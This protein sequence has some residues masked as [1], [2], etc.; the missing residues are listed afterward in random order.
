[1]NLSKKAFITKLN[2]EDVDLASNIFDK[3]MLCSKTSSIV[4]VTYFCT[5]NVWKNLKAISGEFDVEVSL[6]GMFKESDRRM[7]AFSPYKEVLSFPIDLLKVTS[8]TKFNNIGHRDY[9]GAL[10]ALGIKREKIGDLVL[11]NGVCYFPVCS[12]LSDYIITNLNSVGKCPCCAVIAE[13]DSEIEIENNFSLCSINVAS[14]RIDSI[15]AKL[16]NISRATAQ[17][18]IK[19]GKVQVDYEI[20]KIDKIVSDDV[21]ITIR[22][23][24]KYKVVENVGFTK[25]GK[26]KVSVKKYI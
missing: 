14:M 21:L 15:V 16:C 20:C 13:K 2:I 25:S 19:S 9:L 7:I 5:P 17:E 24:G 12:E 8:N 4:F 26:C 23:F 18:E 22:G 6:F 3:I 1:M 11:S 10:M